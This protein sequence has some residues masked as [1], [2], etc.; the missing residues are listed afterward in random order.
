M[1]RTL[2]TV[3]AVLVAAATYGAGTVTTTEAR[4][5][6]LKRIKFA[7]VSS[8]GGAADATTVNSFCGKVE[9]LATIPDGGGTQP[10]DLYDLTVTDVDG[11][12]VLAGAGANRSNASTQTV[13]SSS[14]GAVCYSTLTLAI[15][16]AGNAKGGTVVL[17]LR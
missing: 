10:T 2:L 5:A 4:H 12:D 1:R 16:N 3:L 7:W 6:A 11:I 17:Y 8:A 15:T 9:L 14:L 13:V